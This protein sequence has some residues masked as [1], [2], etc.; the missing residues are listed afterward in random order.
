MGGDGTEEGRRR[1]ILVIDD[2]VLVGAA[3]RR[4]LTRDHDV[5][6]VTRA[7]EALEQLRDGNVFD[8]ILC[9]LN[10]PDVSGPDLYA[11][12]AERWPQHAARVVFISGQG[13]NAR[14]RDLLGGTP[15]IDKPFELHELRAFI[16]A[17]LR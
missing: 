8:L 12:L 4:I 1:R 6:L 17:R 11:Q 3:L 10:M 2:E 5:V 7:S 14:T 15:C 9:D 13:D 16:A